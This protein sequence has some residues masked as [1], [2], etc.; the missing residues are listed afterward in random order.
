LISSILPGKGFKY[1]FKSFVDLVGDDTSLGETLLV[2]PWFS[3]FVLI[4]QETNFFEAL[5]SHSNP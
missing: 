3:W 2:A 1:F 4:R 5:V